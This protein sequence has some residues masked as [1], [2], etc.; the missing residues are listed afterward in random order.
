[1][2]SLMHARV[3]SRSDGWRCIAALAAALA[4]PAALADGASGAVGF[5]SAQVLR[6]VSQ[7]NGDASLSLDATYRLDTGWAAGASLATLGRDARGTRTL[8]G[9]S[10]NRSWQVDR[11][12]STQLGIAHYAYPGGGD[13][14]RFDYD[15]LSASVGWQ[16]RLTAS[17]AVLPNASRRDENGVPRRG[18]AFA[19]ELS[20]HE[21]LAGQLAFDAGI[22]WMDLRN[23]RGAGY[24]Y[25]S[26]GLGLGAGPVQVF[27]TFIA[28]RAAARGLAAPAAG[29]D[30]FLLSV[31]WD[32]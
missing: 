14:H 16:G 9:L 12:W 4:A 6:G 20:V 19:Y 11:D 10:V 22:G 8:L 13:R 26:V 1:M 28:S 31:L 25:G 24:P 21:R 23:I 2:A 7:S 3:V 27:A 30:R 17:V 18:R 15:E 32:F 29:G 5:A